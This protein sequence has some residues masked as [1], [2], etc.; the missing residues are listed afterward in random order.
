MKHYIA[1]T[2]LGC[3]ILLQCFIISD[4]TPKSEIEAW[5]YILEKVVVDRDDWCT[6][7]GFNKVQ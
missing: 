4:S 7:Q 6:R 5:Q 1:Y 3:I 2:L